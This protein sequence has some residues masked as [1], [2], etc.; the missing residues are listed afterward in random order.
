MASIG[1]WV[2]LSEYDDDWNVV[3]VRA[4]AV[5]GQEGIKPDTWYALRGGEFVQVEGEE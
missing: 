1:G 3:C 5:N 2:V 4:A